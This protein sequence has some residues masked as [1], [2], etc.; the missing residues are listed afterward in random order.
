MIQRPPVVSSSL[1]NLSYKND[2]PGMEFLRPQLS[3]SES[4]T[5]GLKLGCEKIYKVELTQ[6]GSFLCASQ[7]ARGDK[8]V[9]RRRIP[10]NV[11]FPP[12]LPKKKKKPYPIPIKEIKQAAREDK[13]L[14]E[15]G[16][17]K[18][19]DPPKNGLL[20]PD[21]IPVAYEVFDAWKLLIKGLGQLLH[22]I[23]VH[24]CSECSEVH[25]GR[26]VH[27]IQDCLGPTSAQ[28]H[29]FHAWVKGS[30]NDILIPVESYHLYDP[31]G[32]RIKHET[33]FDYDRIPAV[34]EL[35]IQAGVD[36]L[37][38]PSRRRTNPI[39]MLG[40]R[41]ID[42]GGYVEEPKPWRSAD[43][44]ALIDFDTYQAC[45]RFP[46]P[47][48]SDIPRIAQETIEAYETVRKG[49]RTLMKKYSVKACGYCS[50][51]HVGPWGH[52][53]KLCG[54]FKHQWRDGKHGWQDATVEEVFPPNYVWHVRD[55]SGPP[56]SGSLKRF[57]GKAPAV[58]EVC[59]QAGAKI[60]DGYKP[61]M[62]LDIVIPEA[63]EAKLIA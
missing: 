52:N 9:E 19:L 13:K 27:H 21:L 12:V 42:R 40:K 38:Y 58:V 61:M 31:F 45:D 2:C 14:A 60:P 30:I 17:E 24:G 43:P 29:S 54:A 20:V 57:Y 11:D 25:V 59:M 22:V 49:V 6:P 53:A 15:M 50:E 34:V 28:R 41:V 55:P 33:R 35:C 51:V 39:R 48:S 3:A 36:I 8:A 23:P 56:L 44:S 32:R 46:P 7:K 18:P 63:D 10:Q 37:E 1:W 4:Y 5:L 62:R 16:I 47:Q 26:S